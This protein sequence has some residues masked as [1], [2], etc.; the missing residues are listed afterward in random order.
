VRASRQDDWRSNPFKVKRVRN[1][2]RGALDA[3]GAQAGGGS[4]ATKVSVAREPARAYSTQPPESLDERVE[5]IL[6]LVKNQD[7]Y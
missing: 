7:E 1:A 5:R 2:I 6:V 3:A 4:D